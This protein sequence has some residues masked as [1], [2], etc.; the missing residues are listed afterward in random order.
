MIGIDGLQAFADS[1]TRLDMS[2]TTYQALEAGVAELKSVLSAIGCEPAPGYAAGDDAAIL[3]INDPAVVDREVG[4]RTA[5]PRAHLAAAT[6]T[7]SVGV[8][9]AMAAAVHTILG[10]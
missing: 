7:Y 1:L 4:T 9:E 2:E 3:E 6:A 8:V 10:S 5:A